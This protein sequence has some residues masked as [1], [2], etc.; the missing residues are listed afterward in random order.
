MIRCA[1]WVLSFNTLLFA[2]NS[3]IAQ[4]AQSASAQPSAQGEASKNANGNPES[5][6]PPLAD[7]GKAMFQAAAPEPISK[8]VDGVS[9]ANDAKDVLTTGIK[10]GASDAAVAALQKGVD[11]GVEKGVAI[12]GEA[13][14]LPPVVADREAK[15]VTAAGRYIRDNTKLGR[16]VQDA[17]YDGAIATGKGVIKAS[18]AAGK[19]FAGSEF[20]LTQQVSAG[21]DK[22]AA[23]ALDTVEMPQTGSVTNLSAALKADADQQAAIMRAQ[24]EAAREAQLAQIAEEREEE[25]ERVAEAA[26]E[27]QEEVEQAQEEEQEEADRQQREEDRGAR[28]EEWEAREEEWEERQV[29][30]WQ[31]Q[32]YVAWQAQSEWQSAWQSQQ[33]GPGITSG[34]IVTPSSGNSTCDIN[35]AERAVRPSPGDTS[36]LQSLSQNLNE[37]CP[38][39]ALPAATEPP[40]SLS[41]PSVTSPSV[42]SPA[43]SS[44]SSSSSATQ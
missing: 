8:I 32:E 42:T 31:A 1:A 13:L 17:E 22:E 15:V 44:S 24:Q 9:Y 36:G 16:I 39:P 27:R 18:D 30:T 40:E 26:E 11:A 23:H 28:R 35:A 33:V 21:L 10:H 7:L 37:Y 25:Q 41:T 20:D 34:A 3:A 4:D 5:S 38:I 6:T 43:S 12:T 14:G 19:A 29:E 2:F